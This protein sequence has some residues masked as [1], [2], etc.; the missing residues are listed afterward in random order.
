[1][2]YY[3]NLCIAYLSLLCVFRDFL[4]ISDVWYV[5]YTIKVISNVQ[6]DKW[7]MKER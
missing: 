5:S 7:T 3:K 1:M 2:L 4:F 6:T